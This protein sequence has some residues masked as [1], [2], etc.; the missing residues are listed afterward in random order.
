M[1]NNILVGALSCVVASLV[2]SSCAAYKYQQINVKAK[3]GTIVSTPSRA[4][5]WVVPESGNVTIK[6]PRDAY[7]AYMWASPAFDSDVSVP[8][9]LDYKDRRYAELDVMEYSGMGLTAAGL[10]PVLAGT[11]ALVAGDE[12][13][14]SSLFAGGGIPMLIGGGLGAAGGIPKMR[15]QMKYH[16]EYAS[17]Q[18]ANT[19]L[20]LTK[21][22]MDYVEDRP[23][24][25]GASAYGTE[26]S[27]VPS[28]S[29]SGGQKTTKSPKT[30]SGKTATSK[31]AHS[32]KKADAAVSGSYVGNGKLIKGNEVVESYSNIKIV[33]KS[34]SNNSQGKVEVNV[35]ESNGCEYFSEPSV[36]Y[37]KAD[38]KGECALVHEDINSATITIYR[39]GRITY[40]HPL[41][42]IDGEIYNLKISGKKQNLHGALDL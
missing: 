34:A 31:S 30:I 36:Y 16:F 5:T 24:A 6:L 25:K 12:D 35:T 41:V 18:N 7:Y 38:A 20:H 13:V 11:I 39:D 42:E 28:K 3:P 37:V 2:I 14:G 33:I 1:K 26:T 32:I 17:V 19:D 8:F 21:P 40:N 15:M 10:I 9:A 4:Q 22:V 27:E 23:K 29:V